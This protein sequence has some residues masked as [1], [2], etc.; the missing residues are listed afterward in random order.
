MKTDVQKALKA[1]PSYFV[2]KSSNELA[3]KNIT[4][5]YRNTADLVLKAIKNLFAKNI[6]KSKA[7]K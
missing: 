5:K 2:I 1:I 3:A 4:Q 6:I 7:P